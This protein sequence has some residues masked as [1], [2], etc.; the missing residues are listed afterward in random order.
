LAFAHLSGPRLDGEDHVVVAKPTR[1]MIENLGIPDG[2]PSHLSKSPGRG[3][4]ELPNFFDPATREQ[5]FDTPLDAR[6][7]ILTRSHQARDPRLGRCGSIELALPIAD[8]SA[9]LSIDLEGADHAPPIRG[10]QFR[11]RQSVN[12]GKLRMEPSIPSLIR[13]S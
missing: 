7:P 6:V 11:R 4:V 10:R 1:Q 13:V 5:L 12:R 9:G 3:L 8:R 2:L